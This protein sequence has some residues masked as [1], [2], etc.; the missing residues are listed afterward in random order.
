MGESAKMV[1]KETPELPSSHRHIKCVQLHIE[2]F[3]MKDTQELPEDSYTWARER[4]PIS[5]WVGKPETHS[6]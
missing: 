4:T 2:Q 5:R 1:T 3:L 6:P